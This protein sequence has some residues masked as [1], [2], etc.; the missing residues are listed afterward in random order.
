MNIQNMTWHRLF[1]QNF[2]RSKRL[3][4]GEMSPIREFLDNAEG[5]PHP[6]ICK[7]EDCRESAADHVYQ[8]ESGHAQRLLGQYV[9]YACYEITFHGQGRCGFPSIFPARRRLCSAARRP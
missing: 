9:P 5:D 8:L 6:L 2:Y 1:S 7:S 3:L 4:M